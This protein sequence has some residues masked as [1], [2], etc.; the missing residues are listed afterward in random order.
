MSD[1][2]ATGTLLLTHP[3]DAESVGNRQNTESVGNRQDAKPCPVPPGPDPV[4]PAVLVPV[5]GLAGVDDDPL[6]S[7]IVRGI[8]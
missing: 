2:R 7:H 5:L 1:F 4:R 8:D 3:V 6:E